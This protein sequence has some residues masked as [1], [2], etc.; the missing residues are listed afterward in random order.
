MQIPWW[1]VVGS[2][3]AYSLDVRIRTEGRRAEKIGTE[4]IGTEK[5]GTEKIGTEKIGTEKIGEEFECICIGV[6]VLDEYN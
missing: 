4:K 1:G 6:E 3:I 5:I 2:L